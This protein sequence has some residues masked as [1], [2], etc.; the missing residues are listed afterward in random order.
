MS[1]Q[2]HN[3]LSK[4]MGVLMKTKIRVL[5]FIVSIG[6]GR[7]QQLLG[8][9]VSV[10]LMLTMLVFGA[11]QA[12]AGPVGIYDTGFGE[13]VLTNEATSSSQN[14]VFGYN[15]LFYSV[16]GSGN[17]AFGAFALKYNT[18]GSSNSALGNHSLFYNTTGNNNVGVGGNSLLNNTTGYLNTGVGYLALRDNKTG[19]NNTALGYGAGASMQ[20]KNNV[21]IIGENDGLTVNDGEVLLSNGAGLEGIRIK[22]YFNVR[23]TVSINGILQLQKYT[24]APMPCNSSFD[25]SIAMTSASS[26]CVCNG[27]QW[28]SL[29]NPA[30]VCSW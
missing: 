29:L 2:I 30:V 25:G 16:N 20:G 14:S 9:A 11:G 3:I 23:A 24:F 19:H 4:E 13:G 6:L 18:S 26:L 15:A 22:S 5:F 8:P 28:N 12:F 10:A 7:I 27:V 17:D 1:F 21:V